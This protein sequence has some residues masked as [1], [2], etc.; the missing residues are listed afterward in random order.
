MFTG[1]IKDIGIIQ[2]CTATTGGMRASVETR[3]SIA[4]WPIGASVACSGVCLTIVKKVG[5]SFD[6]EISP[7]TL[8]LTNLGLWIVGTQ[9]NLEPSLKIGD[10]LDGHFVTGHVDG[11][12]TIHGITPSG[13][14][15]DVVITAP[16]NLLHLIAAKGSITIDGVALTVNRITGNQVNVMIIPHTWQHTNFQYY[17]AGS[18]VNMEVDILARYVA[19]MQIFPQLGAD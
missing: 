10:P 15:W 6:V 4:D 11:L 18:S 17:K 2:N 19:R 16:D 3:L 14:S 8:A 13:N 9:V 7:E 12:G 1:I 5:Q